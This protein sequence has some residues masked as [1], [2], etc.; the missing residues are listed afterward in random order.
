MEES[1]KIK[2]QINLCLMILFVK[3]DP[4]AVKKT[5][6]KEINIDDQKVS[7]IIK[8]LDKLEEQEYFLKS[9]CSL[10]TMA[11]KVK[12]NATYLSWV[13]RTYKEKSFNVYINRLRI[14][15]V[16][17]RLKKDKKFRFFSI[18]SI[19][20]EIGYKSNTSFVKHFKAK[21]GLNPSYYIK[22]IQELEI[23]T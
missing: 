6:Q 2:G 12:T 5:L 23:V 11:K 3:I 17:K 7:D 15:Y 14:E 9:C 16:L 21:T 20:L 18:E 13:I 10:G 1:L 19:S 8:R 22:D 4:L